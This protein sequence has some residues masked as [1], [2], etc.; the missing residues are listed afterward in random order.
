LKNSCV[1]EEDRDFC[2]RHAEGKVEYLVGVETLL[3]YC[4]YGATYSIR[5]RLTWFKMIN[6]SGE[7]ETCSR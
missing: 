7:F 4:L 5:R 3:K 1:E 6:F 2:K